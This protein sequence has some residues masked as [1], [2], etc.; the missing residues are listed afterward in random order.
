M[1][2]Q[3]SR[4][5]E[6]SFS[7]FNSYFDNIVRNF[8]ENE[9]DY[10]PVPLEKKMPIDMVEYEDKF[11][12]VA[13]LPGIKKENV[14][15]SINDNELVILASQEEKSEEQKGTLYR[16]ERYQGNYRRTIYLN[17]FSDKEGIKANFENGV[18]YLAI[19]KKAP[20]PVQEISIN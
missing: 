18:L 16:S 10:E 13:N 7:P 20:K 5:N 2:H 12:V 9:S 17:D 3:L 6:R 4:R 19:P 14:K 15:I 8:F 11:E 1:R